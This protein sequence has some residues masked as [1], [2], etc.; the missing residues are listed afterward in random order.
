MLLKAGNAS[1]QCAIMVG[2]SASTV[3]S[4]RSQFKKAGESFPN[5]RGRKNL[6]L[7]KLMIYHK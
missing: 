7:N 3:N 6:S 2:I 4:L 5:N 1:K